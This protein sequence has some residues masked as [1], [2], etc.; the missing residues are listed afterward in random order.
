MDKKLPYLIVLAIGL[1]GVPSVANA[2]PH[3]H[4]RG[5]GH[6]GAGIVAFAHGHGR[7]GDRHRGLGFPSHHGVTHWSEGHYSVSGHH[8]LGHSGL[9]GHQQDGFHVSGDLS[10]SG[11]HPG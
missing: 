11:R 3:G 7:H 5:H 8:T 1:M 6:H 4:H 10:G 9:S 2:R